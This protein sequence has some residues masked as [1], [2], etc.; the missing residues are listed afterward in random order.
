MTA[1]TVH[2]ASGEPGWTGRQSAQAA[3]Q[4]GL[5]LEVVKPLLAKRGFLLVPRREVVERSFG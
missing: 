1:K 3:A 5:R 2:V 4:A